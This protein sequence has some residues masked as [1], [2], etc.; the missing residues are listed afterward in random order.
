[1]F[2]WSGINSN[3]MRTLLN[4]PSYYTYIFTTLGAGH[5]IYYFELVAQFEHSSADG[6]LV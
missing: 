5:D 2:S 4:F 3:L 6:N 1:M